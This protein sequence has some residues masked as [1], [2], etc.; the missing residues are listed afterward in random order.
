MMG[1]IKAPPPQKK[2]SF[3]RYFQHTFSK[4]S[5]RV[6]KSCTIGDPEI[7]YYQY[8]STQ[9]LKCLK[10]EKKKVIQKTNTTAFKFLRPVLWI[11]RASSEKH[12]NIEV[13]VVQ[14]QQK[15]VSL[16]LSSLV[17]NTWYLL[18]QKVWHLSKLYKDNA[19]LF[20]NLKI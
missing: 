5:F 17:F 9:V 8:F 20:L 14:C 6:L 10:K 4:G 11:F 3:A 18:H 13:L 2:S 7:K 12:V 1:F 16:L 15:C 19:F